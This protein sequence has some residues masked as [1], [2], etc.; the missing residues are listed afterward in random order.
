[1]MT[2]MGPRISYK[3]LLV[4]IFIQVA[5]VIVGCGP[6]NVEKLREKRDVAK[7]VNIL[8]DTGQDISLRVQAANAFLLN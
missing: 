1:M 3:V 7:L 2:K 6:P 4:V 5:L 8:E